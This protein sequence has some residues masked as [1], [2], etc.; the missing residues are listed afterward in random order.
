MNSLSP[1]AAYQRA[2]A[3]CAKSEQAPAD[4]RKK[5]LTAWGLSP[6]E[7]DALVDALIE[8]R[9][10]DEARYAAAFVRDKF[11]FDHWGKMKIRQGL[12]AKQISERIALEALSDEI[13]EADYLAACESALAAKVKTLPSPISTADVARL[14]RF[15]ATKGYESDT[16]RRALQALT[17]TLL[18]TE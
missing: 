17:D 2:C 7:A 15:A 5:A 8:E 16:I 4:I 6:D 18:E 3:L 12:L 1:A 14:F 9:Y 10:L 13:N 11:R